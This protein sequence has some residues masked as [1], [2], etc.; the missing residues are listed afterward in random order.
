[1]PFASAD[2]RRC[3]ALVNVMLPLMLPVA[4]VATAMVTAF[5]TLALS[6][7]P[8]ATVRSVPV[9]PPIVSVTAAAACRLRIVFE[10]TDN[11]PMVCVGTAVTVV[12]VPLLNTSTSVVAVVVRVGVQFVLVVHA[13]LA[14][15]FH[16]YVV[17]AKALVLMTARNK[18]ATTATRR[19]VC[20]PSPE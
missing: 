7:E 17:C 4:P 1:M 12:V 15:A 9:P 14:P 13:P 16:V 20:I 6:C 11:C 18:N 19:N 3:A 10:D 8:A 2:V 5:A